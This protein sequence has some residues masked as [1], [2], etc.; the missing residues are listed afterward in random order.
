MKKKVK[1]SYCEAIATAAFFIVMVLFWI[2]VLSVEAS[3]KAPRSKFYDFN[4]QLI[5]GEV[6]KPTALFTDRKDKVKFDRLL[7]LK[8]SF[9]PQLLSTSKEKVFK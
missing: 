6:K 8:K 3:A 4:Q 9:L 5:D 1:H 2:S 7:N